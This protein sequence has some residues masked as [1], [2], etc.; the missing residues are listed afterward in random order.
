MITG[1][2]VALPEEI[3]TLTAKKIGKG[4]C[5]FIG[6]SILLAC[7]GAGPQNAQAAAELLLANGAESLIS[8][9]CAAALVD[10]LA[11]GDLTLVSSL[12]TDRLEQLD[13]QSSWLTETRQVLS[14]LHPHTSGSL[15]ESTTLVSS[16]TEK[17]T[18]Q[19]RTQATVLDME[20]VAIAK[21]A[22]QNGKPFLAVRAIADPVDMNLPKAIAESL[23]EEG[24]VIL[25][26]LL[27]Y[28]VRHPGELMG[29]IK[30]G[31]HFNAAQKTLKQAAQ[32]LTLNHFCR[33]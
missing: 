23:S 4:C 14:E 11:P 26:K 19:R 1:I 30:L 7:S 17:K 10:T 22:L 15:A 2:V 32:R 5:D 12:V 9:G 33:A 31:L 27:A 29:L 6:P 21:V 18:T 16:V 28:L 24:E 13:I 20:S 8:W 25:P 3:S